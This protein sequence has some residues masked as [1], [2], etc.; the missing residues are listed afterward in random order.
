LQPRHGGAYLSAMAP[1]R[2][3]LLLDH[4]RVFAEVPRLMTYDEQSF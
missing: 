3:E 1:Q 2:R 4:G